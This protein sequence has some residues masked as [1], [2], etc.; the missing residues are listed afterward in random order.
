[1]IEWGYLLGS[2]LGLVTGGL[3]VYFWLVRN[4]STLPDWNR[5]RRAQ[6]L[7]AAATPLRSAFLA[8]ACAFI[9]TAI[10]Y[11]VLGLAK[12][13]DVILGG[14]KYLMGIGVAVPHYFFLLRVAR[15][16]PDRVPSLS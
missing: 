12:E 15:E 8:G 14:F 9:G 2:G 5:R 4:V 16:H 10:V 1:M 11:D 6:V 7:R 3:A 13:L